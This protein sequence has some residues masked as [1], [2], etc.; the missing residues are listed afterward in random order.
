MTEN[1]K[2]NNVC[3][4]RVCSYG[5]LNAILLACTVSLPWEDEASPESARVM[6]HVPALLVGSEK[7]KYLDNPCV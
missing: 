1:A 3:Q 7:K 4:A 5:C 2:I 6:C